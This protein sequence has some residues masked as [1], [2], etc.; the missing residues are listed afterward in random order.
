MS[1]ILSIQ[2]AEVLLGKYYDG[3]TGKEEEQLLHDFLAREDVPSRFHAEKAMFGYFDKQKKSTDDAIEN[4]QILLPDFGE[5]NVRINDSSDDYDFIESVLAKISDTDDKQDNNPSLSDDIHNAKTETKSHKSKPGGKVVRMISWM[6][7]AAVVMAFIFT[8]TKSYSQSK[9]DF[10]YING[11]KCTN[12]NIIKEEAITSM[13]VLSEEDDEVSK[14]AGL[15]QSDN[16]VIEQQLSVFAG[17][18]Q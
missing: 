3:L 15:L 9:N 11:K 13:N 1:R 16:D 7:V 12:L 17:L 5:A 4:L 2:E 8:T 10:A 18:A 6:S 14:S